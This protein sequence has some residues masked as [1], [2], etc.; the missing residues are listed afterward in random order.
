MPQALA[1]ASEPV[2]FGRWSGPVR[3]AGETHTISGRFRYAPQP[4]GRFR[5]RLTKTPGGATGVVVQALSGPV[6]GLY[7]TYTGI[8]PLTVRGAH[9]EDF[10]RFGPEGVEANVRSLTWRRSGRAAV[11]FEKPAT[12]ASDA[13]AI[14]QRVSRS[15]RY[16]WLEPRALVESDGTGSSS[17]AHAWSVLLV[18]GEGT[19]AVE[20]ITE[21]VPEPGAAEAAVT[22]AEGSDRAVEVTASAA[23]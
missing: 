15:S 9:G 8:D 18:R 20:G 2:E 5:T 6:P 13:P 10:L 21:W 16:A 17:S 7:L 11:S 12:F 22:S 14:W 23:P 19:L 3:L 1:S 4:A